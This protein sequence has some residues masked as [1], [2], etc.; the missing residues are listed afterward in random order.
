MMMDHNFRSIPIVDDEGRL[1]GM[2]A[3]QELAQLFLPARRM[4]RPS[5]PTARC[6]RACSTS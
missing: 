6:A 4:K 5:R 2:P 1:L 3:I